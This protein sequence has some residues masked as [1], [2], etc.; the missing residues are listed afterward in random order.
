MNA[1]W[2]MRFRAKS[3]VVCARVV[4]RIQNQLDNPSLHAT[5]PTRAAR[6]QRGGEGSLSSSPL[7]RQSPLESTV[8][9]NDKAKAIATAKRD[10]TAARIAHIEALQLDETD[11]SPSGGGAAAAAASLPKGSAGPAMI[12]TVVFDDS[13][14]EGTPRGTPP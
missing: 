2:T 10:S 4:K 13:D 7:A 8:A 12:S 11:S 6:K 1:S 9:A 5:T 14:T 3:K